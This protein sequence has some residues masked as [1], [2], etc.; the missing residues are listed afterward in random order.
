MKLFHI[1]V[2]KG[3]M[4]KICHSEN[5]QFKGVRETLHL[6]TLVLDLWYRNK[7]IK[8]HSKKKLG[9]RFEIKNVQNYDFIGNGN[10]L[11]KFCIMLF[12]ITTIFM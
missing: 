1:A 2:P 4:H 10:I 7:L 3:L 12:F 9:H 11:R 5:L 6:Y 8:G